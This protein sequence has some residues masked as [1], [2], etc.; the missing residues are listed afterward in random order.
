MK[1]PVLST[2]VPILRFAA[3]VLLFS[4]LVNSLA[5]AQQRK[6]TYDG[7]ENHRIAL[8]KAVKY[9]KNFRAKSD[10]TSLR[11]GYFGRR[12]FDQI[13]SQKGCVGI[14]YYYA[15][16]DSGVST[17][18]LVGV[19]STGTDM[20]SGVVSEMGLICPPWCP[21]SSALNK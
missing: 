11:G 12:A 3:T 17:L 13:L 21:S 2:F 9:V 18:V 19:D 4:C 7:K 20:T 5:S 15:K 14:R 16:T 10:S 1:N 8:D 6:P